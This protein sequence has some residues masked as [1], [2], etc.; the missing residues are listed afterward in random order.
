M[1][2]T[3][4]GIDLAKNTFQLH[5][6]DERGQVVLR[7]K[8][9]RAKLL[10]YL[11]NLPACLIGMEACGGAH[12]WARQIEQLGHQV[13]LIAPKYVKPYLQGPKNDGNDAD[14]ICEA[15]GRPRTRFVAIKNEHQQDMLLLHRVREQLVKQRTALAN[16][17]RGLLSERGIVVPKG[18]D[19]L[20]SELEGI[21]AGETGAL[22]PTFE[23]ILGELGARLRELK[24]QIGEYDRRIGQQAKDQDDCQRALAVPGV[25]PLVATAFVATVGDPNLF[26]KGRDVSAWLGLVP[27]QDSTGGKVRLLGITK[28]GDGYLRKLLIHGAR[29][30]VLAAT[31]KLDSHS[32]WINAVSAR[33]GVNCA[34]V[35]LANKNARILWAM[36]RTGQAYRPAA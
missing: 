36:M 31:R 9:T 23:R 3:T 18:P 33:R 1:N 21:V 26:A 19:R 15:V 24:Q 14:A 28:R 25:G 20:S 27:G 35:A 4:L 34:T 32:Q 6:V 8:L 12:W 17:I 22:T 13:R 11:A 2:I 5:G 16:Q 29:S 10:D 30:A 7:K